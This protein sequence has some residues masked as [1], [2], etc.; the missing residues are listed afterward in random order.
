MSRDRY[1]FYTACT[2]ASRRLYLVRQAASD[3]GSPVEESPF[4][5]DAAAV[6][7]PDDV[8]RATRRR[9]LSELTWPVEAAPTERERLRALARLSADPDGRDVAL[10]LAAANGWTRRLGRALT[11]FERDTP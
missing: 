1:L 6:F 3:E 5:Q 8:E 11:A 10:A 2:R 7:A 4:W 9:A